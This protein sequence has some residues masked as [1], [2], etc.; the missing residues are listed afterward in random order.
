M[1]GIVQRLGLLRQA[2]SGPFIQPAI[3]QAINAA[4]LIDAERRLPRQQGRN[5]VGWHEG[6]RFSEAEVR[7]HAAAAQRLYDLFI[8]QGRNPAQAAGWAANAESESGGN[9][10][11]PQSGGGPAF[12]LFQLERP[13]QRDF[14]RFAGRPIQQSSLRDQLAFVDWELEKTER[15][16][17]KAIAR[18][19]DA[20]SIAAVISKAYLRPAERGREAADR[21]NI[22]AEILRQRETGRGSLIRRVGSDRR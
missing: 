5:T 13:R 3:D 17:A 7:E 22:A 8:E 1:L 12:G 11:L 4:R 9:H 19:K 18:Q 2:G 14:R 15:P 6:G 10:L 20:G 21:A 16:A